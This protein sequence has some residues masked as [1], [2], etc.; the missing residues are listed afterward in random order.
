MVAGIRGVQTRHIIISFY[1]FVFNFGPLDLLGPGHTQFTRIPFLTC[2][3]DNPLV[4]ATMAPFV[5]V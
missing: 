3:L 1:T 2:W 5:D 4:K